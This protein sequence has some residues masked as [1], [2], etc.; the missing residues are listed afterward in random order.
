MILSK[1]FHD[2][3]LV[4]SDIAAGLVLLNH[5]QKKREEE[6]LHSIRAKSLSAVVANAP[7]LPP[8]WDNIVHFYKFAFACYG[9]FWYV[10]EKPCSHLLSMRP[11]LN[12]FKCK[13]CVR[14][15]SRVS[16]TFLAVFAHNCGF[17]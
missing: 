2:R 4:M 12:C 3:D 6:K 10:M 7:E 8:D 9:Y 17:N 5:H 16:F 13:C 15:V 1:V 14:Q 11:Y